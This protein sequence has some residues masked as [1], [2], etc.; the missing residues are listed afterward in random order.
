[1]ITI[2]DAQELAIQRRGL[3]LSAEY[4]N[5]YSNLSWQCS[6]GHIW[7]AS[8]SN[9]KHHGTWC[10]ECSV[11][12]QTDSIFTLQ[13]FASTKDGCLISETY[14]NAHQKLQW[15][16]NKGH[17]WWARWCDIKNKKTWCPICAK[18]AKPDITLLQK[19]AIS[20]K[21]K[22]LSTSYINRTKKLVWKCNKGHEWKATWAN[23]NT[24]DSWCPTCLDYKNELY[25]RAYLTELF[26]KP[27]SKIKFPNKQ[28]KTWFELDGYNKELKIAFEYN[29]EQH[30]TYPNAF[31]KTKEK[32]IRCQVSDQYKKQYCADNN[33][34]LIVIPYTIKQS[35][36]RVFISSELKALSKPLPANQS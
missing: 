30:Y 24:R 7:E 34:T 33:I 6:K 31:H 13:H 15:A 5:N 35:E 16:C 19:Y 26:K 18:K 32:F 1:M 9:V 17:D 12:E 23:I 4:K 25:C 11:K 8:Y 36:I 28:T 14:N 2:K 27:F 20:K 22:L 29:G 3:L 10:R 21:G